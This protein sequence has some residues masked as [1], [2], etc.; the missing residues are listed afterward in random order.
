MMRERA[1]GEGE[2]WVAVERGIKVS[3]VLLYG[4]EGPTSPGH[5]VCVYDGAA[6][7]PEHGGDGA[8]P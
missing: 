7:L 4:S 1:R 3:T 2:G 8:F 6:Q 5:Q